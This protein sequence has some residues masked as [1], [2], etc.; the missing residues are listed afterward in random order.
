MSAVHRL[1]GKATL[2]LRSVLNCRGFLLLGGACGGHGIRD[3]RCAGWGKSQR[4]GQEKGYQAWGVFHLH[5]YPLINTPGTGMYRKNGK[6]R[7]FR[8]AGRE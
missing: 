3:R 5:L 4:R 2:F 6:Q 1:H 7:D 8:G